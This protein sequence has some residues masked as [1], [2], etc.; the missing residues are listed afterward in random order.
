MTGSG[1]S[2]ALV[3]G[4]RSSGSGDVIDSSL[5]SLTLA[6]SLESVVLPLRLREHGD[7]QRF[8]GLTF[9]VFAACTA[10]TPPSR[11]HE[12]P[13]PA[14]SAQPV[15]KKAAP[16]DPAKPRIAIGKWHTCTIRSGVVYCWGANSL[17][18]LGD[19]SEVDRS[20]PVPVSGLPNVL[21]VAADAE[22]TCALVEGGEVYCWGD[23]EHGQV[24]GTAGGHHSAPRKREGITGA[25]NLSVGDSLVCVVDGTARVQCWGRVTW[26]GEGIDVSDMT[27]AT[28]VGVG[29]FHVCALDRDR[30][31]TCAGVNYYANLGVLDRTVRKTEVAGLSD[32]VAISIGST[33]ACATVP[34]DKIACWGSGGNEVGTKLP[35]NIPYTQANATVAK[36]QAALAKLPPIVQVSAGFQHTCLVDSEGRVGC[37]GENGDGQVRP[38]GEKDYFQPQ[39]LSEPVD[40]VEVGAGTWHSCALTEANVL[41]CWGNDS[42]GQLGAGRLRETNR[43]LGLTRVDDPSHDLFSQADD[44][45]CV[46]K[47]DESEKIGE[48]CAELWE[49]LRLLPMQDVSR[50]DSG[51]RGIACIADVQGVPTCWADTDEP[52]QFVRLAD[53]VDV[54]Q[55]EFN[56]F[57]VCALTKA[58]DVKCWSVEGS[59]AWQPRTM[60][61]MSRITAI[62]GMDRH[63]CAIGKEGELWCW[64]RNYQGEL[65][66][67][68]S[69][70]R[71]D[72][73]KVKGIPPINAVGGEDIYTCARAMTSGDVWCW[74]EYPGGQ[75]SESLRASLGTIAEVVEVVG[76]P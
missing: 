17:G 69:G 14:Q 52:E 41:W 20:R 72:P 47:A 65:G 38:G 29:D 7:V 37:M 46:P 45:D 63:F 26:G 6:A 70:D 53:V 10:G 73:V 60:P 32:V 66:D 3:V 39:W 50:A 44:A 58:G 71:A 11:E 31:V 35:P 28:Q 62:A 68:T 33:H 54:V 76:L 74:G 30:R 75:D 25:T 36:N 56:W 55:F 15:P 2:I 16:F 4:R 21:A 9:V 13:S 48:P 59:E 57:E 67:G 12:P 22:Y 40:V 64:G 18:Q 1:P 19:R 27:E 51:G 24:S 43:A 8:V 34:S 5:A 61:G 49:Q 42:R 23:D